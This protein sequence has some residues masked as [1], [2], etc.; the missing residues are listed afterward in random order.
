MKNVNANWVP[1]AEVENYNP[2]RYDFVW[3]DDFT[4]FE[5]V[6]LLWWDDASYAAY[7]ARDIA[8]DFMDDD[9]CFTAEQWSE[10]LGS[11]TDTCRY[12]NNES[13]FSITSDDLPF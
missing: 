7:Q 5:P 3:N 12:P 1:A 11:E 6:K 9:N 8:Y 2:N 13:C 4:A 10:V